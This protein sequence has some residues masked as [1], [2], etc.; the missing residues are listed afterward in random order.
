[1]TALL[2]QVAGV[3]TLVNGQAATIVRNPGREPLAVTVELRQR[4]VANGQVT[5]GREVG[6]LVAPTSFTL[7][8]GETQTVRLRLK[9]PVPPGTTLGL[10]V[11]LTPVAG[12]DS[13]STAPVLGAAAHVTL[14]TRL[15]SKVEVMP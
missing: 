5:V 4:F 8:P 14:V 13:R 1:M 11:T 10:V 9:E 6:A 12:V 3:I 7:A 2:A 15:I